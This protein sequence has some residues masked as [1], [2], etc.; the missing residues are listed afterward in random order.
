MASKYYLKKLIVE[1]D[2]DKRVIPQLIEANEIP[3]IDIGEK[4]PYIESYGSDNFIDAHEI[5]TQLQESELTTLGLIVDA[6]DDLSARWTSIRNACL[7]SI[8]D[9]PAQLPKT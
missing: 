4:V 7:K 6:D 1:G 8:P 3:W 5:S 2:Q 9:F